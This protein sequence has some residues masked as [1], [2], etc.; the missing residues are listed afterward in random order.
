MTLVAMAIPV[1]SGFR[2]PRKVL[3]GQAIIL[4]SAY[5]DNVGVGDAMIRAPVSVDGEIYRASISMVDCARRGVN[6]YLSTP[7]VSFFRRA[8]VAVRNVSAGNNV[9]DYLCKIK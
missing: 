5:C 4:G 1:C 8:V 3:E 9:F 7:D 6:I 2:I